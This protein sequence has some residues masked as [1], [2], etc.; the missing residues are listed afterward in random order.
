MSHDLKSE[1]CDTVF[2]HHP[3]RSGPARC[4]QDQATEDTEVAG[5][6]IACDVY[7]S[8]VKSQHPGNLTNLSKYELNHHV[9]RPMAMRIQPPPLLVQ[10][11]P[12]FAGDLSHFLE[13]PMASHMHRWDE[14]FQA[15]LQRGYLLCLGVPWHSPGQA[16]PTSFRNQGGQMRLTCFG[17]KM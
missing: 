3:R 13:R 7:R 12:Y 6:D 10:N 8:W 14:P 16:F 1:W 4:L 9:H 2:F 15:H 5:H 11:S 17:H